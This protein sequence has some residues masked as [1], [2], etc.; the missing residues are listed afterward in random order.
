MRFPGWSRAALEVDDPSDPSG[1]KTVQAIEPLIISAS[2]ST[3]IPAF[4]GEWFIRRL[5]AGYAVWRSPFGGRPVYVSFAK[6]R[7]FAFWSKNP[8]PFLGHLDTLEKRGFGSFFLITLNDYGN[9][10]LEPGVP[11]LEDRIDTFIRLSRRIGAGRVIWRYDPLLLSPEITV[12]DLLNRIGRIGDR[13]SPYTRRLVFSFID[14]ARYAKVRRNLSAAGY[15]GVREF[16][17]REAE[18]FSR[19]LAGLNERWNLTLSACGERRDLTRF[20]IAPGRCI[21]YDLLREEF[22]SDPI[23][24]EFLHLPQQELPG[25]GPGGPYG[26]PVKYFKDPGQRS[27]CGC[28]ISK[29]IGQYSTCPHG[30]VYCYANSSVA[31]AKRNYARYLREAQRGMFHETIA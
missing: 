10:G 21:G 29:D 3:D 5:A 25:D 14:I 26:N 4:Y 15:E 9:E 12:D 8:A 27:T 24:R 20:G 11:P 7:V 16:S 1:K 13:I 19:G 31:A 30:C 22:P 6:A 23:L 18:D 2:R 17:D 28:V